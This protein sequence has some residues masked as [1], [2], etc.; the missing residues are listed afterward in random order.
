MADAKLVSSPSVTGDGVVASNV[1]P[2]TTEGTT[3]SVTAAGGESEE[4][5][6]TPEV[7][8]LAQGPYNYPISLLYCH[9]SRP[10]TLIVEFYF[11]DTNLPYDKSVLVH[12]QESNMD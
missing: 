9:S 7:R 2:S 10:I 4:S 11:A 3:A 12:Y 8:G 1:P 6:E 5:G